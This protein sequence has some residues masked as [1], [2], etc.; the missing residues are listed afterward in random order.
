MKL[1]ITLFVSTLLSACCLYV[2]PGGDDPF[3]NQPRGVVTY[4][5]YSLN[6]LNRYRLK[7]D[8]I[9]GNGIMPC[10]YRTK[11][12]IE[13]QVKDLRQVFRPPFKETFT[14]DTI[15]KN[16]RALFSY[17]YQPNSGSYK[18]ITF[19]SFTVPYQNFSEKFQEN[20][21]S[22]SNICKADSVGYQYV[23]YLKDWPIK[24]NI[25]QDKKV[26][27]Y[28]PGSSFTTE[29]IQRGPNHWT[30]TTSVLQYEWQSYPMAS[31]TWYLPIADT[32]YHLEFQFSS[33]VVTESWEG[34]L[35][36][37]HRK[38]FEHLID[39]VA[40]TPLPEE[41]KIPLEKVV[42]P[43]IQKPIPRRHMN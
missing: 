11:N 16:G 38:L 3:A 31:E 23:V 27:G 32:S 1:I 22:F 18:P 29:E 34:P 24:E 10:N 14:T 2:P 41:E 5:T 8:W 43:P 21:L 28:Y 7:H 42:S 4:E 6:F 40:I 26:I 35:Y 25:A 13:F 9:R 30:V 37:R 17:D 12:L 19:T 15:K 20:F 39:S 36:R 33:P